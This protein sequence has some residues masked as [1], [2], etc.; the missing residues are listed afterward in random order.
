MFKKF[1]EE[2]K[3]FALK[4]N[5]LDMAVGVIIGGAFGKIVTSLVNDIIMPPIGMLVG[6]V[7]FSKLAIT[8]NDHTEIRYGEFLNNVIS[9]LIIAFVIFVVIREM[10]RIRIPFL[11]GEE[12][13]PTT[14]NCPYCCSTIPIHA[15]RCPNCTSELSVPD[16]TPS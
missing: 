11:G 1:F 13:A 8:L 14:K 9:F 7:D 4:G 10:N 15:T 16:K 12:D 2:F 6:R 5:V 3:A